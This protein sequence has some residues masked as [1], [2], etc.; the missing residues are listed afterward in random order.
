MSVEQH[1]QF[2]N[3]RQIA[4]SIDPTELA[5]DDRLALIDLLGRCLA[6]DRAAASAYPAP[7]M[8][9]RRNSS[10]SSSVLKSR[11]DE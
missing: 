11:S 8:V 4:D 3:L 2:I 10:S 1:R 9:R 5:L 6:A 7:S